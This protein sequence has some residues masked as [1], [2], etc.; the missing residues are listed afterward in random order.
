MALVDNT[1]QDVV[2]TLMIA[3]S[4]TVS[5]VAALKATLID[6]A[7]KTKSSVDEAVGNLIAKGITIDKAHSQV[8][9]AIEF[10][11]KTVTDASDDVPGKPALIGSAVLKK[12]NTVIGMVPEIKAVVASAIEIRY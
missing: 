5:K 9:S 10:L 7:T 11:T 4:D 12:M 1:K 6:Q 3:Q 8:M 2:A